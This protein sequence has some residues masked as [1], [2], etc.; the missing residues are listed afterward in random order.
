MNVHSPSQKKNSHYL[1]KEENKCFVKIFRLSSDSK[2][3]EKHTQC[4]GRVCRKEKV[5]QVEK[6]ITNTTIDGDEM[7]G[8]VI[9]PHSSPTE[10]IEIESL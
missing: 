4:M 1:Q 6:S 8:P 5:W 9:P 2:N 7:V 10:Y 3:I